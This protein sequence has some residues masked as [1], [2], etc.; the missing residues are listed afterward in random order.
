[1][2]CATPSAESTPNRSPRRN[3]E[4]SLP[5]RYQHRHWDVAGASR[6]NIR[7]ARH[8]RQQRRRRELLGGLDTSDEK[9]RHNVVAT[10]PASSTVCAPAS[11]HAANRVR[12]DHQHRPRFAVT[13]VPGYFAYQASKAAVVKMTGRGG[14]GRD[15]RHPRQHRLPGLIIT[16]M[17]ETEPRTRSRPTSARRLSAGPAD[18]EIAGGALTSPPTKRRTS[19]ARS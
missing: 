10:R 3:D 16:P 8:P 14:R 19:P 18:V 15:G 17:T 5:R 2:T 1:M 7:P 9:W 11:R 12:L 13:A 6:V 4:L